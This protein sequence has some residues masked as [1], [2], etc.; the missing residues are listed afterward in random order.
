MI[1]DTP[2]GE[3]DTQ[4]EKNDVP[5]D[6][7][8]A[9]VGEHIVTA[10]QSIEEITQESQTSEG[11]IVRKSERQCV[12]KVFP[13]HI[14]YLCGADN[15]LCGPVN[16]RKASSRTDWTVWRKAMSDEIQS[17]HENYALGILCKC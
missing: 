13:K 5:A 8:E 11:V 1:S 17:F 12:P 6:D 15:N 10:K 3:N 14:T 9:P 4:F 16:V 2:V 7:S